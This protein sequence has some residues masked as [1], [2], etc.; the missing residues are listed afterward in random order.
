MIAVVKAAEML[1]FIETPGHRSAD[2]QG[3]GLVDAGL[4]GRRRPVARATPHLA[5]RPR[6]L[7]LAPR[8]PDHAV[9]SDSCSRRSSC[10]MPRENYEKVFSTF[11]RW[12]RY[13]GLFAYDETTQR[14]SLPSSRLWGG[15]SDASPFSARRPPRRRDKCCLSFSAWHKMAQ[16]G[17]LL[18]FWLRR[19]FSAN[20]ARRAYGSGGNVDVRQP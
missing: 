12:A 4:R 13:C 11:I 20:S 15:T 6:G 14:I 8:Q 18:Q 7:G 5:P 16:N 9:D 19:H 1:D 3:Q 10:R 17:T 2:A